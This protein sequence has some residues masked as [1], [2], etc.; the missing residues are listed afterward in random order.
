MIFLFHVFLEARRSSDPM[1]IVYLLVDDL[2]MYFSH[3][4]VLVKNNYL[5]KQ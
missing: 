4:V 3:Y 1:H 2:G 5:N